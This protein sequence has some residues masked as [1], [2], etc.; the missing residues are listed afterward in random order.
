MHSN[1]LIIP[2]GRYILKVPLN[3][4]GKELGKTEWKTWR[5]Y[6]GTRLLAPIKWEWLGVVC[7]RRLMPVSKVPPTSIE[8]VGRFIPSLG[9]TVYDITNPDNWGLLSST[10]VLVNYGSFKKD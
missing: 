9:D 10:T 8:F 6:G 4:R 2:I 7:Q 5:V 1:R 3:K